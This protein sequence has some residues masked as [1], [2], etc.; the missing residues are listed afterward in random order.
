VLLNDVA[1]ILLLNATDAIRHL[2][3][4][5]A[6][7]NKTTGAI[8]HQCCAL[9]LLLLLPDDLLNGQLTVEETL[10][11]TAKLRCPP[12]FSDAQRQAKVEQVRLGLLK[13]QIDAVSIVPFCET[14]LAGNVLTAAVV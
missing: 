14:V 5:M 12:H 1:V 7:N 11:Y 2:I 10:A 9:P 6:A 3:S 8:F 13:M 4:T